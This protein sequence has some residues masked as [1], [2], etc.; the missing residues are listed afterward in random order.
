MGHLAEDTAGG[1]VHDVGT[2]PLAG[3]DAAAGDDEFERG[4]PVAHETWKGASRALVKAG[5]GHAN[6]RS[7]M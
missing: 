1:G 6:Q 5:A 2:G 3:T 7:R 4:V